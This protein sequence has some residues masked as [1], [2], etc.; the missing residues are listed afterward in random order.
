MI[1]LI[2]SKLFLFGVFDFLYVQLRSLHGVL[3]FRS[4][5]R[6]RFRMEVC[7]VEWVARLACSFGKT[8][9]LFK[10]ER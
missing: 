2:S 4:G 9:L 7:T 3:E 8:L 6:L 10:N 5:Y 1:A